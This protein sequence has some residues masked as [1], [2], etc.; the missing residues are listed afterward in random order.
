MI[1]VIAGRFRSRKLKTLRG[2][3]TRPTSDRLRETLFN[4]LGPKV[5]GAV[6]GDLYAGSGAVGIEAL[7]RGA[8][9]VYF[10]EGNPK[11][12][13]VICANLEALG[14]EYKLEAEVLSLEITRALKKL[15]NRSVRFDIAF[16]DPPYDATDEYTRTL[17]WLGAGDLLAEGAV[18]VVEHDKRHAL[19]GKYGALRCSRTLTQGDSALSF[20]EISSG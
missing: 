19:A 4:V 2:N 5:E 1:R 8:K 10:P 6:F 9:K 3:R 18:V 15:L 17:Q 11:A 7:S 20:F 16:L 12:V 13:Q 14:I